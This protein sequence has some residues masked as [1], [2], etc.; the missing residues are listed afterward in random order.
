MPV[1]RHCFS[2]EGHRAVV[3][4]QVRAALTGPSGPTG[5]SGGSCPLV[6]LPSQIPGV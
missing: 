6:A 4:L 1:A 5:L 2:S 3:T